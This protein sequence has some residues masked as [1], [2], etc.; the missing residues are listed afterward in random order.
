LFLQ[1]E[2]QARFGSG[3]K[4]L[5]DEAVKTNFSKY[6]DIV[7]SVTIPLDGSSYVAPGGAYEYPT[8][9]TLEQKIEAIITQKWVA[10]F[11]GNGFEAFFDK[12]RTGYPKTS[13]VA[14]TDPSYIPGQLVYSL[15][16]A[17]EGKKFPKR[18]VYPQEETNTNTSSPALIKITEP[19]WWAKN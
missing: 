15:A 1:A 12:N 5:Y 9:G 6:S 11:P 4:A 10:G 2:A 19:V 3:A 13:L 16:G 14:Q 7:T 8:S 17:T 18:I